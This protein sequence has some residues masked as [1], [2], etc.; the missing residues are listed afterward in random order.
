MTATNSGKRLVRVEVTE[1]TPEPKR[2][3]VMVTTETRVLSVPYYVHDDVPLAQG[4]AS[5]PDSSARPKAKATR[6]RRHARTA[7][8]RRKGPAS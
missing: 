5:G 1:T 7:A 4:W 8:P 2:I 3:K 6:D